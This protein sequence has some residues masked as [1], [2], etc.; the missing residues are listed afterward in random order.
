MIAASLVLLSASAQEARIPWD[1]EKAKKIARE[2]FALEKQ[3]S[4]WDKVPWLTDRTKA[5][6]ESKRTG[7]PILVYYY[8]EKGGPAAAPC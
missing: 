2:V 8:V 7:K 6:E 5:A 3:G 4:T 1:Q